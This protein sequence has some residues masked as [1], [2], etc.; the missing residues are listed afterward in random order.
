MR[1]TLRCM[2]WRAAK[3]RSRNSCVTAWRHFSNCIRKFEI[4]KLWR[5]QKYAPVTRHRR[6]CATRTHQQ[7]HERDLLEVAREGAGGRFMAA[8]MD[9]A[10]GLVLAEPGGGTVWSRNAAQAFC[11]GFER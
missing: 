2:C 5:P 10:R 3:K 8:R 7:N 9:R 6:G 11:P 4:G 1:L